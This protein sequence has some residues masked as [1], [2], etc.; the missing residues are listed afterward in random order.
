MLPEILDVAA[1]F[2]WIDQVMFK[3]NFRDVGGRDRYDDLNRAID[4]ATKANIG[5]VA[6]KTQG[7]AVN[8]PGQDASTD[9]R[10]RV[11]RRRLPRSS[12]VWMDGRIHV[13]VS[14]MT[15]RDD[16]RENVAATAEPIMSSPKQAAAGR[17][18]SND[19]A[20]LLPWLRP[21]LRDCRQGRPGR[22]GSPLPPILRGLRKAARR[23]A[24]ST[25]RSRRVARNLAA[26][27]LAAADAAC[28]HGLP[29]V[30]LIERAGSTDE[31]LISRLAH[32]LV[33]GGRIA[34]NRSHGT[35][36]AG[37]V[38]GPGV[39]AQVE[40]VHRLFVIRAQGFG[41]AAAEQERPGVQTPLPSGKGSGCDRLVID[42]RRA[43]PGTAANH[44][45]CS[46]RPAG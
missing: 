27:D 23:P 39:E 11:S 22:H 30:E 35:A 43:W 34:S 42:A 17:L 6:M 37:Q 38:Q 41:P 46:D 33:A 32:L 21:P 1:E 28:P 29:V 25:R 24:L 40:F 14:E 15:T 44:E 2:G 26:A 16:L 45:I 20:P 4:K 3:Y 9:F 13:A 12:P 19:G 5:L 18:P 7:G 36:L 10:R 31:S 8:F